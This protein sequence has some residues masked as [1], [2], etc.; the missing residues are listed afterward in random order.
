M[1]NRPVILVDLDNVVYD[2]VQSMAEWL[3]RN[4]ALPFK[5][6]RT[7]SAPQQAMR[8][9]SQWAVWE[10]WNIPKG[11]FMRWWRLGIEAGEIYGRGPIIPGARNALWQLS[12]REWDIHIATSR[13]TKF[14]LHDKIIENSVSWLR[15]NGIPYRNCLFISDK[16]RVAAEAIVD[17]RR[18]NMGELHVRHYE[19]PANHNQGRVVG[20]DEQRDA[21][22]RIVGEL[23]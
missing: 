9:Y 6:T 16:T 1:P 15:D 11:E 10:D 19:F 2:W 8:A 13:L 7:E 18:D 22:K 20:A 17:D 14:G 4:Y 5:W 23:T 21:W 3:D 12:D